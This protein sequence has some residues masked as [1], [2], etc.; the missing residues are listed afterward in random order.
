MYLI[1]VVF[2]TR[3][4]QFDLKKWLRLFVPVENVDHRFGVKVLPSGAL[5]YLGRYFDLKKNWDRERSSASAIALSS[6][7]HTSF[8]RS[9]PVPSMRHIGRNGWLSWCWEEQH[10]KTPSVRHLVK[11]F[12]NESGWR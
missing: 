4:L 8:S 11:A 7:M 6:P 1:F 12:A 9:L 10:M 3:W 5:D 2:L